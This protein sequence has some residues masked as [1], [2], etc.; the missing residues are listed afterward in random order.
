MHS[1]LEIQSEPLVVM[2]ADDDDDFRALVV[3]ALQADG[4]ATLEAHDGQ[5]LLVLLEQG[6][7]GAPS[8]RPNLLITDVKMPKLSGLGVLEVLRGAHSSMPVVVVSALT[9]ES[10][11][12]V[13]MRLGAV[14]VLHK[15][16]DTDDLLTAVYNATAV[17]ELHRRTRH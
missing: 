9:D 14:G 1:P 8:L 2:V 17:T 15:P 3:A 5:E 12:T 13:A 11:G 16:F 6:Q 10:I 4:H 7:G